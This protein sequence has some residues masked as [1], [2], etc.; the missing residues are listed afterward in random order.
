MPADR[1]RPHLVVLVCLALAAAACGGASPPPPATA[2]TARPS[3]VG[4]AAPHVL[5]LLEENKDYA[6]VIGSRQ[7][8][9]LNSLAD[10]YGVATSWYGITHPSLPN[11]L[12]L[13]SGS[14]QGV[15]G[16]VT[17]AHAKPPGPTFV[18]QLAERGI[19]WKAYMEDVPRP[20]DTTD[21]YSP[22]HYDVNH[23]PFVYFRSVTD[24]PAQCQRVVPYGQ[25]AADL[26][27]DSAPPFL[28]VSP[29]TLHDMHDAG[30]GEAD[31]WARDLVTRVQESAWY[32]SSAVVVIT[33]DEGEPSERIPT[34]VVSAH[35][36]RGARLATRGNHYG[37]LRAL[38]ETYGLPYLGA[39]ADPSSGDLR[40]LFGG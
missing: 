11:Y 5:V 31:D 13:V 21:T 19:G 14:V 17:P 25:L 32:R 1:T 29:N 8:P 15:S 35:T 26:A 28:W 7:A 24:S 38:Q 16:D 22:G 23:N 36:P 33:W 40:P 30:V 18:D 39:S 2:A 20:C 9:F 6:S 34:I 27:S 12:A 3:T 37:T 4:G 10:Q